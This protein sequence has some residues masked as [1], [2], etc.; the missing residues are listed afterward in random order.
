MSEETREAELVESDEVTSSPAGRL[1]GQ[2]S[3]LGALVALVGVVIG[4]LY[5]TNPT[6]GVLELVPD[7]VPLFGN[8][9]E[10]AA[11][12]FLVLGLQYLFGRDR[13]G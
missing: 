7:N 5:L 10:A 11:T 8:L 13:A 2:R 12:T 3:C 6:A 1:L 9:D 4:A